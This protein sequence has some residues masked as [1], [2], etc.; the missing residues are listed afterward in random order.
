M[1]GGLYGV[2]GQLAQRV[3]EL[4]QKPD[5]AHA[6]LLRMVVLLVLEEQA[7]QLSAILNHVQVRD[8]LESRK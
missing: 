8:S 3:V 2:S 7:N 5:H 4:E 1:A 6:H